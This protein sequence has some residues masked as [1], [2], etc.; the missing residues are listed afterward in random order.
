VSSPAD[1]EI[2]AGLKDV[3]ER[4]FETLNEAQ[5]QVLHVAALLGRRFRLDALLATT[6]ADEAV[7]LATLNQALEMQLIR[8][9]GSSERSRTEQY[10][11][12]HALIRQALQDSLGPGQRPRLHRQIGYAR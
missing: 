5:R 11:F 12:E 6:E 10:E 2:P 1:L 7:I 3:I 9:V 8:R 4:R